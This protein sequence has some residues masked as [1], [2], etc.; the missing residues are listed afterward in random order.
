MLSNATSC[1]GLLND[2]REGKSVEQHITINHRQAAATVCFSLSAFCAAETHIF[3]FVAKA[4][5][6]EVFW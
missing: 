3:Y 4:S 2:H 1:I 6:T 5:A